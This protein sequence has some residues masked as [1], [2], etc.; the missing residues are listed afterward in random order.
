MTGLPATTI[1]SDDDSVSTV[2]CSFNH[3][4]RVGIAMDLLTFQTPLVVAVGFNLYLYMRGLNSLKDVPFSVLSR[5]LLR[6]VGY[7]FVLL[8]VWT[9]NLVYNALCIADRTDT[10][11][12]DLQDV[13]VNLAA[14]QALSNYTNLIILPKN[15]IISLNRAS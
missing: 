5:R 1:G 11:H 2:T 3:V 10:G 9:P 8:A 4:S 7:I 15:V 12:S 6:A 13:V 14:S